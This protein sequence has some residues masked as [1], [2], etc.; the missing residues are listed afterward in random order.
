MH[1]FVLRV[2]VTIRLYRS[3]VCWRA[4]GLR[5]ASFFVEPLAGFLSFGRQSLRLFVERS[6]VDKHSGDL[7]AMGEYMSRSPRVGNLW[8]RATAGM[9]G[10]HPL[11]SSNEVLRCC[12][13][14]LR[15]GRTWSRYM[16]YILRMAVLMNSG[17]KYLVLFFSRG[18]FSLPRTFLGVLQREAAFLFFSQ[19]DVF[20]CNFFRFR[21]GG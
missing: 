7:W 8:I 4:W 16:P 12:D 9:D 20:I 13:Q 10:R 3:S 21:F 5:P 11:P 14:E 2:C 1:A 17:G 15:S 18:L 19:H 6:S